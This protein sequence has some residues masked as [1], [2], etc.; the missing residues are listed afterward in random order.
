MGDIRTNYVV[1][2]LFKGCNVF[3]KNGYLFIQDNKGRGGDRGPITPNIIKNAVYIEISKGKFKPGK[4]GTGTL[5]GAAVGGVTG[6]FL[7]AALQAG[8]TGTWDY[9]YCIEITYLNGKKSRLLLDSNHHEA[10]CSK[11]LKNC[12]NK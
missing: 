2:G 1:S 5:V 12:F 10:A 4:Q 9:N 3:Q 7:G 6:A 11:S 8:S